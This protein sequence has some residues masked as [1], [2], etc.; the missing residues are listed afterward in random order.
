MRSLLLLAS[1]LLA[2][3]TPA[4]AQFG[5]AAFLDHAPAEHHATA[6]LPAGLVVP[7]EPVDGHLAPVLQREIA[8]SGEVDVSLVGVTPSGTLTLTAPGGRALM[9]RIR[10]FWADVDGAT[11]WKEFNCHRDGLGA[12]RAHPGEGTRR[13]LLRAFVTADAAQTAT[14]TAGRYSGIAYFRVDAR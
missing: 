9:V 10:C 3:A 1:A 14:A 13:V 8:F 12:L 7:G 6:Y 4:A 11:V 5:M 2:P